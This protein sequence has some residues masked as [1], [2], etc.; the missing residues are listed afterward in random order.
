MGKYLS[1]LKEDNFE[2]HNDILN[3]ILQY[4]F[5]VD[6]YKWANE[7]SLHFQD[8]ICKREVSYVNSISITYM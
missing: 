3:H 2:T 6:Y 5:Q 8:S 1:S 7:G 4:L